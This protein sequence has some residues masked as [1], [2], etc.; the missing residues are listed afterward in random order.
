MESLGAF[1]SRYRTCLEGYDPRPHAGNGRNILAI[2]FLQSRARY[3][4]LYYFW[5]GSPMSISL[6]L[7]VQCIP[8]GDSLTELTNK[9]PT[10]S[11]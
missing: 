9:T 8:F 10:E 7:I 2:R 3:R 1:L 4:S 11:E 6:R 5:Q